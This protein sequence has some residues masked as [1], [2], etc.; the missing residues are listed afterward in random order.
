ML[1]AS[2]DVGIH[3]DPYGVTLAVPVC[4][5]WHIYEHFLSA[6]DMNA[7]IMH[8]GYSLA[9]WAVAETHIDQCC[10]PRVM[11][12]STS[13]PTESHLPCLSVRYGIYMSIS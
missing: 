2:G 5:V 1:L 8:I 13:T 6:C 9:H 3:I 7:A 12:E 10:W 4:E 11:L